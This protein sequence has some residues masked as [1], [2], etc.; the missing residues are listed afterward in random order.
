MSLQPPFVLIDDARTDADA[1][2]F[3]GP[4]DILTCSRAEDVPATLTAI[5][6]A[7]A[8]GHYVAGYLAYELGYALEPRLAPLMPEGFKTPLIWMG[9]FAAPPRRLDQTALRSL[10]DD[11][12]Q[13]PADVTMD[14]PNVAHDD[15]LAHVE[16]VREHIRAGDVYQINYTFKQPFTLNGSALALYARLRNAQRAGFGTVIATGTRHI[17]SLSPELFIE[18]DGAR[19]RTRPMKGTA[20]RAASPAQDTA[21]QDW[22]RTDE[23]SCAENLMIVDLLRNDLGRIC[24]VGSVTVEALFDVERYPTVHQM[25]S[26]ITGRLKPA[27]AIGDVVRAL[28]PCGSVTGAPKVKAMEVIRTLET[29]P[30]GVYT[31]AVGYAGPTGTRLNVAIR[32]LDIDANGRNGPHLG[33]LGIGSGVVF[34]SDAQ[35]EWEECHLKARFLT[36]PPASFALLETLKWTADEGFA[37]LELHLQRLRG[38]AAYFGY[39]FARGP[40]EAALDAAVARTT[41]KALRLRLTVDGWGT[42]Q[43]DAQPLAKPEAERAWTFALA[44][45]PVDV[46]SPFTYHKTT[47]RAFYDNARTRLAA[48]TGCDEAVFLNPEGEVTE[49]SFTNVFVARD[50]VLL[51]PPVSCGLLAGTLRADLLARGKAREAVLTPVDLQADGGVFLGNSVRGLVPAQFIVL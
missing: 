25:T 5:D 19:V 27:T 49:G 47:A 39:P 16:Q 22:L 18:T 37:L 28:F 14:A 42:P 11:W 10:I 34:D 30:R 32:T 20:P 33:E 6:A 46:N 3:E 15:Y 23:K 7:V 2:L 31:G 12:G 43:V 8:R 51:T 24:E 21:R 4:R 35:A 9:V 1:L 13:M 45:D 40:I 36:D 17:L 41:A 48:E 26:S 38:S 50:G 29:D 44:P